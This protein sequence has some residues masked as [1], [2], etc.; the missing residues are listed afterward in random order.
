MEQFLKDF[1]NDNS[2][3]IGLC[4]L[5]RKVSEVQFNFA[6][7]VQS[8]PVYQ[9]TF[10][11]QPQ[12]QVQG[13]PQP[14]PQQPKPQRQTLAQKFAEQQRAY[15]AQQKAYAAR[16]VYLEQQRQ[17]FAQVQQSVQ[18]QKT[19]QQRPVYTEAKPVFANSNPYCKQVQQPQS[20][21]IIDGNKKKVISAAVPARQM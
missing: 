14:R 13:R 3:C 16:Q 10:Y 2:V 15:E 4:D 1:F 18:Q 8:Q 11:Q 7:Q 6:Q 17:N 12:P 21:V 19:V 9:Q 5:K 20:R